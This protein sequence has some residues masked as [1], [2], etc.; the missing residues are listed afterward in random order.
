MY[1]G[2]N[3]RKYR[4]LS[5]LIRQVKMQ[6]VFLFPYNTTFH[7]LTMCAVCTFK[8]HLKSRYLL[9]L[10]N[11]SQISI[12]T[13]MFKCVTKLFWWSFLL[14]QRNSGLQS[15]SSGCNKTCLFGRD[16]E[17]CHII[18]SYLFFFQRQ[19]KFWCKMLSSIIMKSQSQYLT[20]IIAISLFDHIIFF[21]HKA[22]CSSSEFLHW[23]FF[24]SQLCV[25]ILKPPYFLFYIQSK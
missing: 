2:G 14:L 4:L 5:M 23:L 6:G 21:T 9:G 15:F 10:H 3:G 20:K 11:L 16:Q 12:I 8:S 24:S 19:W 13:I 22:A 18:M 25:V 17:K 1:V 7:L